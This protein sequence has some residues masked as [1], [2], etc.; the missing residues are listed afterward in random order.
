MYVLKKDLPFAEKG[1]EVVK[2]Y[3]GCP[4]ECWCTKV[5]IGEPQYFIAK[6]NMDMSEWIEEV[7]EEKPLVMFTSKPFPIESFHDYDNL[8]KRGE[9]S[10]FYGHQI[11]LFTIPQLYFTIA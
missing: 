7:E 5:I 2:K 1:A 9:N 4:D 10:I 8:V 11:R 3:T 6:G